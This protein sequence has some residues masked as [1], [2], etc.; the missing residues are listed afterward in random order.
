MTESG[1]VLEVRGN[2]ITIAKDNGLCGEAC[3]G[4]LRGGACGVKP[5]R[6][7]AENPLNL[8]LKPGQAV[9]IESGRLFGQALT[10]LLPLPAG[11]TAGFFLV[12]LIF[13]AAG[14]P[15]RMAGGVLGLFAAAAAFCLFRRCYPP[16]N[17]PRIA[18]FK[19][20]DEPARTEFTE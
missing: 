2:K 4:C 16:R 3:F 15:S 20:T 5:I 9:K 6:I 18:G 8:P 10:A 11:F 7:T 12:S 17:Q 1:R 13:P 19:E 14:D